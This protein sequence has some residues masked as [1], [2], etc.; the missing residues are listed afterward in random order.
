MIS[1]IKV[2]VD[3]LAPDVLSEGDMYSPRMTK[4]GQLFTADW[5][6]RLILAGCVYRMSV[7]TVTGGTKAVKVGV[8]TAEDLNMPF[9]VVAID[10]GYLIPI[11]VQGGF[12]SDADADGDEVAVL[13]TCDKTTASSAA[14]LATLAGTAETPDNLLDGGPTFQGRCISD[15]TV[16]FTQPIFDDILFY[17][18]WETIGADTL[19][20]TNYFVDHDFSYPT[21]LAGPCTLLFYASGTMA[22]T[23]IYSIVFAHIPASWVPTS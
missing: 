10:T 5:I 19:G 17:S 4:V 9:G 21:F 18:L 8:G 13:L 1:D 7:G 15:G 22:T 6:M 11:S 2:K 12:I 3:Q 23:G 14:S 20:P 16:A